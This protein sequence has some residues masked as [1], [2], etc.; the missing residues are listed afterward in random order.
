MCTIL[1]LTRPAASSL[2]VFVGILLAVT[3]AAAAEWPDL[4]LAGPV[5]GGGEKDSALIFAV[6]DYAFVADVAGASQNAE[7]WYLHFTKS[8]KVPAERVRLLRDTEVT[9]ESMLSAAKEAARSAKPGGTLWVV[10]IGHGAPA[11]D[12]KDGVL[13]GVDAQQTAESLYARSVRQKELLELLGK[14]AQAK[15]LAIVDACFSGST[16]SG[17][18]VAGLQPLLPVSAATTLDVK[19]TVLSAGA[20]NQFAGPLP[21]VARP[22]FSYLVLGALRGWG[23]ADADGMVTATEAVTYAR[24]TIGMVVKGRAQT[25]EV[26]FGDGNAILAGSAK[27]KG[28]DLVAFVLEHRPRE[29]SPVA[30]S[31]P[32]VKGGTVTAV[33][34]DLTVDVKPR[35]GARLEVTD[36]AGKIFEVAPPYKNGAATI[37]RWRALA[38]A[39]GYADE[40]QEFEVPPDESTVAKLTL[41]RLGALK[42]VGTPA[43]AE[44]KV[45]GPGFAPAPSGLPFEATGLRAATYRVEVSRAGYEAFAKVVTIE[46]GSTAEVKVELL[47]VGSLGGG[48]GGCPEGMAFVKGGVVGLLDQKPATVTVADFCMDVTEVTVAAYSACVTARRCSACCLI[49]NFYSSCKRL[50]NWGNPE[51]ADHPMNCVT[52][53][54]ADAFCKASGKR[55]P[56]EEEWEWAARGGEKG[57]IYPWGDDTPT[58]DVCW[59]GEKNDSGWKARKGTCKVGSYGSGDRVGGLYDLGGN[60]REW[61]NSPKRAYMTVRGGSWESDMPYMLRA[62]G[63]QSSSPGQ[64]SADVGFRCAKKP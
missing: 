50:P 33:V 15:T 20:G 7:D 18:L 49:D 22:A 24:S 37:G 59:N 62:D 12:G 11:E 3:P 42:V 52:W 44:V 64:G 8:R 23:D 57:T 30:P 17:A 36:P 56:S 60:V 43:G 2:A 40:S 14:G 6:E 45:T 63:Q 29:A 53:D 28:P 10:F 4:T 38:K 5:Q 16:G 32:A 61:T 21:G 27:E 35:E 9:R 19:A 34:G 1:R 46:A 31:G 39:D 51:R 13:V 47:K 58:R 48:T 26:A 25:P 55:L 41:K 54:Q